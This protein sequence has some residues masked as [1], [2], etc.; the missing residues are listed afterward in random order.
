MN[1][2]E[3]ELIH[4]CH[5]EHVSDWQGNS[6]YRG[7]SQGFKLQRMKRDSNISLRA[8]SSNVFKSYKWVLQSIA[9]TCCFLQSD[10]QGNAQKVGDAL[11]G[12]ID[13]SSP[14]Q[15]DSPYKQ[16]LQW[17]CEAQKLDMS[18][19][20]AGLQE[21]YNRFDELVDNE[22]QRMA[23]DRAVKYQKL[24][25]YAI[26]HKN[27]QIF[28]RIL[29]KKSEVT[30]R[31]V[32]SEKLGSTED[33]HHA[34]EQVRLWSEVW[35]AEVDNSPIIMGAHTSKYETGKNTMP[36]TPRAVTQH[37]IDR[38][39]RITGSFSKGTAVAHDKLP[40]RMM[41]YLDDAIL[42]KLVILYKRVEL[43]GEWP[44]D[45]R[46]ANMVM[47]PKAEAF[48]WRHI[49]MLVTPYRIW[50]R[51]AGED[52]SAW[53]IALKRDCVAN[54]P[55]KAAE[56][57]VHDIAIS[58]E[59]NVGEYNRI[60]VAMID[61]LEKGFEKVEHDTIRLKSEVYH[62]PPVVLKMALSMYTG[63]RRIR[64][65][66]AFSK[67][68]YT[69]VGVLAGCSIAMGLFLLANLD[70][71]DRFWKELPKQIL[72]SIVDFKVYVD[73]FMIIF[74]FDRN[75][76]ID[77]QI[78]MRIRGA[79]TRLATK[80]KEAGGN[81]VVGKGKVAAT[82][83]A[84]AT[85]NAQG[86]NMCTCGAKDKM[87]G[88]CN[89]ITNHKIS[90]TRNLTMLGVDFAVGRAIEYCKNNER[91][92]AAADKAAR[93]SSMGKGG[94]ML[95][96]I[97]RMHVQSFA[98]YGI[99]VNG[100]SDTALEKVRTMVR[101]ATSTRASG[102]SA[103]VVFLLQKHRDIDPAFAANALPLL[104][105]ATRINVA[106]RQGNNKVILLHTKAWCSAMASIA[107]CMKSGGDPWKNVKGPAA[108]CII[109]LG[110][111]G[112]VYLRC[113]AGKPGLIGWAELLIL[114]RLLRI[115]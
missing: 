48:K 86:L 15:G 100:I 10:D 77:G 54:G 33:Q 97:M 2:I 96:N 105:W 1:R 84:V 114:R 27:G 107:E 29:R 53:M 69:K 12:S 9:R 49:A 102:G 39:R 103:T 31:P 109:T 115:R 91:I 32:S 95:L 30:G 55:K 46:I 90:A 68:A 36:F 108:A 57:A 52:V 92:E 62:F 94:L 83:H 16:V 63:A 45:W 93:M 25:K 104:Q 73:D 98:L 112:W 85:S 70:P 74:S 111:I 47:I 87:S 59:A 38:F 72:S 65:G 21:L 14:N 60:D 61:D 64:C 43:K 67:A 7:R 24:M 44:Q 81:F 99:R 3:D 66:K 79:Y 19:C 89:C 76:V 40:L 56:D 110:R 37:E 42:K 6:P 4:K 106:L 101:A 34:D 51:A 58:T 50:A 22:S 80:I 88:K 75:K 26:R 113:K 28:H 23:S 5:L 18:E 78:N 11:I 17:Y 41:E 8:N 82:D 35:K 71:V 13:F 20:E